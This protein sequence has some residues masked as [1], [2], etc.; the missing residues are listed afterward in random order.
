MRA[1]TVINIR[2]RVGS[3]IGYALPAERDDD[4]P[5]V[6]PPPPPEQLPL[7]GLGSRTGVDAGP[8]NCV[9]TNHSEGIVS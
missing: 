4:R 2:R 3:W 1:S 7:P 5:A 8:T 6:P 9:Q